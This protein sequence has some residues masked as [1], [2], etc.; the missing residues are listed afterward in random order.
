MLPPFSASQLFGHSR[1]AK[2]S[3]VEITNL[4]PESM[5]YFVLAQIVQVRL[6]VAVL[7]QVICYVFG[8]KNVPGIAAI[9]DALANID[10][11]PSH[12]HLIIHI[13]DLIDRSAM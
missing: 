8:Q 9:E 5:L 7:A 6:P 1:V 11:A 10:P 13:G 3:F 4:Q 2:A 12:I